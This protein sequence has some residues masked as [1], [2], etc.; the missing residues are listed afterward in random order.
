[1]K[2]QYVIFNL[3]DNLHISYDND[4]NIC[5][6]NITWNTDVSMAMC[7]DTKQK[8][9]EFIVKNNKILKDKKLNILEIWI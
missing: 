3:I 7:F 5:N 4:F 2:K 9:T 6:K 8:T 1:M